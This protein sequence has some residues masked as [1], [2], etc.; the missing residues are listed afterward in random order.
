MRAESS[1]R[2]LFDSSDDVEKSLLRP[3]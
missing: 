3:V 2:P 1:I